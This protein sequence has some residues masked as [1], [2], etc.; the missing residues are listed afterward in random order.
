MSDMKHDVDALETQEWLAALE[1]VVREEGVERAQYLLEQVLEKARLDGVDMPT[2]V[3]TNYINTIPAAQEPAYPGDTTIERRIRSIIRWN[4]IMIVLR[5]SKKDLE[6]G[7]HMASFQSS[8]AFYETCF[9][10]FFRAPNEKDGGDLVYYQGHISPGI[11]ARAFVEGRLTEEQ[12]DNFRQ[13]VDGK[14]LPSY[15]HPKLMPEFWQFPTVSMGLGPISA[16]YQARFLKY[17]NGRGLKDTTA[18]RVYAFLGDGEMDEPESRGAISFAARE[19]LDNLCFL[20][21]CNLQRLDGPVMGNGKIIQELEGLFRGAGW[22]VVKVIWGNGWDKLLAKDTTGKLLQLMNETIDG[23][24]QTFKAKDGAYVREHFF[25]KYPETAALVAD[26]TDDEIFALKR[27]GHESSKLYAAFKNAQDTKG[28]PTV[29][30]AKTVKGYGMGDAAEGKNIAH[31]VK[32]MDMTHVLAMRNR[33]GLQDLIS[34]EEVKNLPYLKL[35]EG[36]KEFEYLHARRKA[37]HGYTPQRLPNFTGELVIPALEEF[38]PLLEEQSREISSTMAYVRTLN[39]LLKDKNIGQNIVPII[40]DEART[41]GMEGLFR[42]IGIY[43][44][45]GQNY[46]PQDRDIVSY[47]KEATSGQVLQE[48]INELGAMS[49]WVA[50]A[51]SYSTNNLPMIPFYIYYSMFGF[52]RVG[53]MAWM[54]GDQ[55]ARGFLLGA[56]AGRTTLNG[57]GLQHEDGHSHILAGTVPN[58]ISYDPTFAYE[59]AVILQDGIR[60]MYGEQEN[61]FYYLTLMNES[62]AHPAMPAGAEEGIRKGIYKLET[63]AG[64]KAKVQLMSSGTIMNEVRKAAQI[65]SEEY[66][67]ASDVYSVTSFN[68]L[69]RDGQACDRF[70]MLH[71][72]AE[73]KVPYIAQVMGTEPAIAAT[74]YMKNYADQVRAFIPAQSYKVLGTDGFGRSDSR[75]NLRRHFEVNAGYVVVAALNE[76][77]KRGEVEKSVVAAAIKKF[78]I[79]TEKTNPL[80]A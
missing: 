72:E 74:D 76:L 36:S 69:A 35:E 54:A 59:V 22:N 73:V 52:Q 58:C 25:G 28:R 14:G 61:V 53:D 19:K 45:H 51:T 27:G 40:A 34:D 66:G 20:I 16:I 9:N 79:D 60:R 68:E 50:A 64:N 47:Y 1:S 33:L 7:G 49:S 78:D 37:L 44:P 30:L 62:Y 67:V 75:E 23:D 8:A 65:L 29:I 15:P 3:T 26:M 55:Q 39:I 56:T 41:F 70:N 21:N 48:G 42:Q 77:A 11:Y 10:H 57:E 2:G 32:K 24:Y 80:Y 17:L 4:A 63:Y 5:A 43:N 12:L 13:E 71:P 6:L 18:Q 38:K 46:T 31:Q